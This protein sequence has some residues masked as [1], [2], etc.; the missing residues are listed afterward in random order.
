MDLGI[1]PREFWE[2]TPRQFALLIKRHEARHDLRSRRQWQHTASVMALY[3][4]CHRDP[5]KSLPFS[6]EDFM[7]A[8]KAKP[9]P[10]A[11]G[12]GPEVFA[13]FERAFADG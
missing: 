8:A 5:A 4:N 13:A 6:P 1:S 7:P 12:M 2:M 3:A 9:K 11:T 10:E